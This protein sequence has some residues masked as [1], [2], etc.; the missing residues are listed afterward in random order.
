[1]TTQTHYIVSNFDAPKLSSNATGVI[2]F[3]VVVTTD[4]THAGIAL[5]A[6]QGSGYFSREVVLL[7]AL[8]ACT[9]CIP[10]GQPIR[11]GSFRDAFAGK[12]ANN[13]GFATAC[14]VQLGLLRKTEEPVPG[15][16]RCFA[17]GESW[18]AWQDGV[19]ADARQRI[20]SLTPFTSPASVDGCVDVQLSPPASP[21]KRS[22]AKRPS[23]QGN[24]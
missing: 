15:R 12:S 23:L 4:L 10:Q 22:T 6:N 17:I 2:S 21:P 1:M 11:S 18:S 3:V 7:E 5:T 14:L 8:D 13:S 16:G 19:L 9:R 20:E 24:Q